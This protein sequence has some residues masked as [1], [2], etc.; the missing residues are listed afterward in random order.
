[1]GGIVGVA[2]PLLSEAL[3]NS[4][5]KKFSGRA[6]DFEDFERQWNFHL[7]LM[8]S[9]S[10]GV[11]MDAV[12]LMTIKNFLDDASATLLAG[13]MAIDPDLSYD[14]F[15]SNLRSRFLRDAR[16]TH[17]QNWR[18]TKLHISGNRL[19][20]QDWC[21]FQAAYVSRRALV[22][23]WSEM[24]DQ[25]FV[26][27]QT[28]SEF[29]PK[30]LAETG[31]RR[32]G[33][34]WVRVIVPPEIPAADLQAILNQETVTPL[35][36]VSSDKRSFVVA[37]DSERDARTLMDL[38][39]CK[40]A[41]R[42]IKIQRSEYSMTGDDIFRYIQRLL[43]TEEE[44]RCLR[45][46]YDVTG[47]TP[48]GVQLVQSWPGESS[49]RSKSPSQGNRRSDQR[50]RDRRVDNRPR[51]GQQQPNQSTRHSG[52]NGTPPSP[53]GNAGAPPT[54]KKMGEGN[55]ALKFRPGVCYDCEQ[56]QK[57]ANHDFKTCPI[58]LKAWEERKKARAAKARGASPSHA[59]PRAE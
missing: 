32:N 20:L 15:W 33:K 42:V 45:R 46:A 1:M 23:D 30:I 2:N 40:V 35:R 26:F 9:A 39:G 22:E 27:S 44:L 11:L 36:V 57:E 53:K 28:P 34:N 43:E 4:R 47:D 19:S 6:E 8:A 55:T 38:D 50:G 16:A 51:P 29:Q 18:A 14:E 54:S 37:C 59:P 10:N 56:I 12:V 5:V 25:Q 21:Q 3:K 17:R 41:G 24:E 58:H 49:P 52:A 31:K 13:K 48:R 7:K